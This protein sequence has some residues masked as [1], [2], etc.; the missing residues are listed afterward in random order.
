LNKKLF[1][2]IPII[3]GIII[4]SLSGFAPSKYDESFENESFIFDAFGNEGEQFVTYDN[5]TRRT[6]TSFKVELKPGFEEVYDK[7]GVVKEPQNTV[8][9][10]P[11][12]TA[13]AY[14]S[15]G[16]YDY[17]TD[18]CDESCLTS[19]IESSF[20]SQASGNGFQIL[21]LLGYDTITDIDVNNNPEILKKY[22][23]VILLHNEYVTQ[24]EFDAITSHP[25]VIYL[26]PN[27][28]YGKIVYNESE[29]TITLVRGHGFPEKHIANGFDWEFDNTSMEYNQ[30]CNGWEFY[31]IGNGVM[32]NCYPDIEMMKNAELLLWVK[33]L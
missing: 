15:S 28:L 19:T 33:E 17:Y 5:D 4:V 25:K 31:E 11:I 21:T 2:V 32:L 6:W 23:K 12:F 22:D 10:Y 20:L 16:F 27:A 30:D 24:N 13:S 3:I 7:I 9:I 8:V 14:T 18:T 1:F 26:Y 29:K